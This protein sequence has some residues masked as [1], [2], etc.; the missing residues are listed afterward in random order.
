MPVRWLI[1]VPAL[2]ALTWSQAQAEPQILGLLATNN[3]KALNCTAGECSAEFTSFCM[4]PDR[5]SPTH[6]TT[7]DIIS[8]ADDI[9]LL[10]LF[11]DGSVKR[12]PAQ[13]H[14]KFTSKRGFA[15]VR[16]STDADV[17]AA[18]G[19]TRVLVKIG[20]GVALAPAPREHYKRPHEVEEV[21]RAAGPNRMTGSRIVDSGG[22]QRHVAD[23]VSN[24]LNALPETGR[25]EDGLRNSLWQRAISTQDNKGAHRI[26]VEI[27]RRGYSNCLAS[28]AKYQ[29]DTLRGCLGRLHDKQIWTFNR[30]YWRSVSGSS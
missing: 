17:L 4:E 29:N 8:E 14:L 26:A 19:A 10:A 24:L 1:V 27:A 20:N 12:L 28:I 15:A 3:A 30:K 22:T 11:R 6:L 7:Y 21:A 18:H 9:Q 2:I 25:V 23:L 5:A 16:V 13:A